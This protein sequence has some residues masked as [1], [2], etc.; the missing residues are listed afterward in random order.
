[1]PNAVTFKQNFDLFEKGLILF[2]STVN[3]KYERKWND[4]FLKIKN[5]FINI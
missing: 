4:N 3:N 5:K 2:T 1:M